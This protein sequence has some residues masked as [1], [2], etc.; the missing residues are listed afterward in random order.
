MA[1][2]APLLLLMAA[3]APLLLLMAPLA[4]LLMLLATLQRLIPSLMAAVRKPQSILMFNQTLMTRARPRATLD[5][6]GSHRSI[7]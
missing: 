7:R 5:T 3:F 6:T 4:H 1:P 2:L